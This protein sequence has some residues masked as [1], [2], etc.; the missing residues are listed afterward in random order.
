MKNTLPGVRAL[1]SWHMSLKTTAISLD[2]TTTH[3]YT[4]IPVVRYFE[5][6]AVQ[7]P[8]NSEKWPH[9]SKKQPKLEIDIDKYKCVFWK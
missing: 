3:N 4:Y 1:N 9:L 2:E 5:T 7:T 6:K 8:M